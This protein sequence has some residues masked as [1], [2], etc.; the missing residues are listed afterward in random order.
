MEER[1][2]GCMCM[3]T[4]HISYLHVFTIIMLDLRQGNRM[5]SVVSPKQHIFG[6]VAI[7]CIMLTNFKDMLAIFTY[8]HTPPLYTIGGQIE[9]L[10]SL[11][12]SHHMMQF[13]SAYR[14]L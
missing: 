12:G 11:L 4:V 9:G 2:E 3:R 8:L 5:P 10:D 14:L 13:F 1:E 6:V 7:L